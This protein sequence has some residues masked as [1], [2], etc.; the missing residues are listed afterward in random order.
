[1]KYEV[2]TL[3]FSIVVVVYYSCIIGQVVLWF[4]QAKYTLYLSAGTSD[5]KRKFLA[6]Y[7]ESF[8]K[9]HNV[10]ACLVKM[11]NVGLVLI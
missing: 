10:Q 9:Y 4:G 3:L 8:H 6:L 1:M 11:A 2:Y 7:C 5:L